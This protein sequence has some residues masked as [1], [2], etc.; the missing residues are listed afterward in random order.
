M[1]AALSALLALGLASAAK[2]EGII[3]FGTTV[4]PG[5]KR[6]EGR[7]EYKFAIV[8]E[9][10]SQGIV[11]RFVYVV[12]AHCPGSH[13]YPCGGTGQHCSADYVKPNNTSNGERKQCNPILTVTI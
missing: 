8:E 13:P 2:R 6:Q 12:S 9:F 3:T 7:R 10:I 5:F 11:A 4:P 1:L